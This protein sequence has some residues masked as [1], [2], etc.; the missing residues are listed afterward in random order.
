MLR[1]PPMLVKFQRTFSQNSGFIQ[2]P[3][4]GAVALLLLGQSPAMGERHRG[5][6]E[7]FSEVAETT[8]RVN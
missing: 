5:S 3:Q 7:S 1:K 2:R 6:H 8:R 4:P